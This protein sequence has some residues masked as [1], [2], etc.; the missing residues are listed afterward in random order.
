MLTSNLEKEWFREKGTKVNIVDTTLR[1]G[2]QT[3]GV[4]FQIP[5]RLELPGILMRWVL[6]RSRLAFQSWVEMKKVHSRDC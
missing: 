6:I 1:D 4:V 2:E 5:K 3:A